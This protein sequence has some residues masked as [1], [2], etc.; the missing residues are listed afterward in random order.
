MNNFPALKYS[1][2]F[3]LYVFIQVLFLRQVD[4]FDVAFCFVY[5]N[6]IL[7]LPISTDRTLLLLSSFLLGFIVDAFY[8]TLGMHS[9]ACVLI[10]FLRPYLI[11]VIKSKNEVQEASIRDAGFRWFLIYAISLILVH[12]SLLFFLQQF[13]FMLIGQTLI[14]IGASL[15]FTLSLVVIIQYLFISPLADNNA[16]R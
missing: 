5:L 16:R 2:T 12:H 13:N 7:T 6:F 1:L 14:K 9:A 15:L 4:L 3:I 10:A 11:M 8:D